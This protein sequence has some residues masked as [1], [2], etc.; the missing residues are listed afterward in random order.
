MSTMTARS[1]ALALAAANCVLMLPAG[2]ADTQADIGA[3]TGITV[4]AIAGG[5]VGAAVGGAAGALLGDRYHR[6]ASA[7][8]ALAQDLDASESE[9]ARLAQKLAQ[10]DSSLAQSEARGQQLDQ[11]LQQTDE[12]ELDVRFRTDDDALSAQT[13]SPLLQLGALAASLPQAQLI[14]AGY[15]DPRGAQLYNDALSL[16]RAEGVAAVLAG[17]GVPRERMIIEAHGSCDAASRAG[18][19]D[20]YAFDRRVTV[21]LQWARTAQ[22]VSR[23]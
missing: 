4:G 6:Q 2:A 16:R 23:D 9:R 8:Q 15:A 3:A 18:D 5:P 13:L 20:G 14:V 22:V 10:L 1:G 7:R 11:A 17:A 12:L 19:V 21:R